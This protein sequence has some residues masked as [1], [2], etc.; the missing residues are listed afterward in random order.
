MVIFERTT[1]SIQQNT[2]KRAMCGIMHKVL[3][4]AYS[5]NVDFKV[6]QTTRYAIAT[7]RLFD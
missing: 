5:N 3:K 4:W 7:T 2:C 1:F 6:K